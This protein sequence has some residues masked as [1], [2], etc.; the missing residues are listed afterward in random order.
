MTAAPERSPSM[1]K[2]VCSLLSTIVLAC[3]CTPE[4]VGAEASANKAKYI[5][6][7]QLLPLDDYA[8]KE[9][10]EQYF[11][12]GDHTEWIE[13][14]FI[15]KWPSTYYF[16][17][18][19]DESSP[20]LWLNT[21]S[22]PLQ[23]LE[24]NT[25][26]KAAGFQ[27][28]DRVVT[29]WDEFISEASGN[30]VQKTGD[31]MTGPLRVEAKFE[32]GSNILASGN[33]GHAEGAGFAGGLS[34][35]FE[36]FAHSSLD[37][38]IDGV[39]YNTYI[40]WCS[41]NFQLLY[42]LLRK[43]GTANM[44]TKGPSSSSE[45]VHISKVAMSTNGVIYLLADS[46]VSDIGYLYCIYGG[47]ARGEYSHS[48]GE[49]TVAQGESSHSEGLFTL[50]AGNTSHAEG[51]RVTAEGNS[52]HAEGH[53]TKATANYSHVEGLGSLAK[54]EQSHAEGHGT[55]AGGNSSHTEGESCSALGLGAHAEGVAT[56]A[57]SEASH[58]EGWYT[59]TTQ[60]GAHSEGH[61]TTA[62]GIAAHSEGKGTSAVGNSA[63]A[64]GLRTT[65]QGYASQASGYLAKA[66]N[67][68][69]FVW[70]ASVTNLQITLDSEHNT[71]DFPTHDSVNERRLPTVT[72]LKAMFKAD[73]NPEDWNGV[74]VHF[75]NDRWNENWLDL[76][77]FKRIEFGS[78]SGYPGWYAVYIEPDYP[79][80]DWYRSI[81]DETIPEN[82]FSHPAVF[83]LPEGREITFNLELRGGEYYGSHGVGT[84]NANPVG[85]L[86]GFYIGE[87][88]L[89]QHIVNTASSEFVKKS[90][91]TMT[92]PLTNTASISVGTGKAIGERS[93]ATGSA[94]ACGE[95][96]V[97]EGYCDVSEPFTLYKTDNSYVYRSTVKLDIGDI[98]ALQLPENAG[99]LFS[100]VEAVSFF[101]DPEYTVTFEDEFFRY[102]PEEESFTA[103]K[104]DGGTYGLRSHS[105]GGWTLASAGYSHAEGV[106]SRAIGLAGH[107]EGN[108]TVA[109]EFAHSEGYRNKATG[110][111]SHAEGHHTLATG[112]ASHSAGVNALAWDA[113]SYVWNTETT[114]I[115]CTVTPENNVVDLNSLSIS[116]WTLSGKARTIN[117]LLGTNAAV[118]DGMSIVF[119]HGS[120]N[121]T[122]Y[123]PTES[124]FSLNNNGEWEDLEQGAILNDI[125]IPDRFINEGELEFYDAP[126]DWEFTFT[127]DEI[128]VNSSSDLSD[129]YHSHGP[130]T[131]NTN[132]KN[133][134]EGF[135]IGETNLQQHIINIAGEGVDLD[136]YA[137][138]AWVNGKRYISRAELAAA[139]ADHPSGAAD[140][141]NSAIARANAIWGAL[142]DLSVVPGSQ[143][144]AQSRKPA[145]VQDV[146]TIYADT[147]TIEEQVAEAKTHEVARYIMRRG[148][149]RY[150]ND[151]LDGQN[152]G[153]GDMWGPRYGV[154]PSLTVPDDI[155]PGQSVFFDKNSETGALSLQTIPGYDPLAG[156]R[157][158]TVMAWVYRADDA[159]MDTSARIISDINSKTDDS[160]KGFEFGF[161]SKDGK[162]AVKFN[163]G[164]RKVSS[165]SYSA[166]APD[167]QTWTH[168]AVT[169]SN[170]VFN[171]YVNGV[172]RYGGTSA[173][174][175]LANESP[176]TIGNAAS[177]QTGAGKDGCQFFGYIDN[178]RVFTGTSMGDT[179]MANGYVNKVI[180][181]LAL[182]KDE[183][184]KSNRSDFTTDPETLGEMNPDTTIY[185]ADQV[186]AI[187]IAAA[188]DQ[189]TIEQNVRN[190]I[191][192]IRAELGDETLGTMDPDNLLYSSDQT[193]S[194]FGFSTE[195]QAVQPERSAEDQELIEKLED[196]IR[197]LESKIVSQYVVQVSEVECN[198]NWI[199]DPEK[200][201]FAYCSLPP[202]YNW[203][204][205]K[206][207]AT[208]IDFDPAERQLY[209]V[210]VPA[211]LLYTPST[212]Q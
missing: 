97:A 136:G 192:R 141:L 145:I 90:G 81:D 46:S 195:T 170:Y 156:A 187:A 121:N 79:E 42:D 75:Y 178:V 27:L 101:G 45:P 5:I 95:D 196:K 153:Y 25:V 64:G 144:L 188:G 4:L 89:Q 171:V 54:G 211:E 11:A 3:C 105:E 207:G 38:V 39:T 115:T 142:S 107:A 127:I 1:K 110:A 52:S 44:Y 194:K 203:I 88:N 159:E 74:V 169:V 118:F 53:K 10:V 185:T 68:N 113:G 205:T 151:G 98:I 22:S 208:K 167:G 163:N 181:A 84:Y 71:I 165:S 212:E 182:E 204:C 168:L 73:Q 12:A 202:Q 13:E 175:P 96:S 193:Y 209:K 17:E 197:E 184:L 106:S 179:Q 130:G 36:T 162:L 26:F 65:A 125:E 128:P 138:E 82:F 206:C 140:N 132:P 35:T 161:S 72:T 66:T 129:Y 32:Q 104:Y 55:T 198:H 155:Q 57:N 41:M 117:G 123:W 34:C 19:P 24:A 29:S 135:Y 99:L 111:G 186:D 23:W 47:E 48:E 50:A 103:Y 28:G 62:N 43:D 7:P 14:N 20:K 67:A 56:V 102:P 134:L 120:G 109:R 152:S 164:D 86:E 94:V 69:S 177:A 183:D 33:Y 63:H 180:Q 150:L 58:S 116:S 122:E 60:A 49:G 190:T 174:T 18:N 146:A 108:G 9:W 158:F 133:G 85:C 210:D 189:V 92:G 6:P 124:G 149:G 191:A 131:Y 77:E 37:P 176:L 59:S 16:N 15:K 114:S 154:A 119:R 173:S 126:E 40:S 76:N 8:T 100:C 147:P 70:S 83:D 31:T 201:N 143:S 199:R 30:F 78:F 93:F 112:S 2:L 160:A 157:M 21:S 61:E 87:T 51:N 148:G 166:L 137:T 91:D 172:R 139:L 80:Y 200:S